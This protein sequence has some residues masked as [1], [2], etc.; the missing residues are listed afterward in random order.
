MI[1][2]VLMF[3]VSKLS[4]RIKERRV[5]SREEY[6]E[7]FTSAPGEFT[8]FFQGSLWADI[9]KYLIMQVLALRD[10]LTTSREHKDIIHV[11]GEIYRLQKLLDLPK[12]MEGIIKASKVKETQDEE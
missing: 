6:E 1:E 12:N 3:M 9:E 11:Q 8:K 10:E 7:T 2:R 4:E 5:L